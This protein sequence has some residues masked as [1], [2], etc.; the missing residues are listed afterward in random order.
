MDDNQKSSS[1]LLKEIS[2]LRQRVNELENAANNKPTIN[3]NERT[4]LQTLIKRL[5]LIY[6]KDKDCRKILANAAD[7]QNVG[8]HS[9]DEVLG[10]ND[11]EL[12]PED[13]ARSFF[14]DDQKV[15]KTG[16]PVINREEYF[17]TPERQEKVASYI[18]TSVKRQ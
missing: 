16:Q 1:E 9:E 11:F 7:I 10:K 5:D 18:K 13:I 4:L 8:K 3:Q 2:E 14:E 17:I 12:F 15:I 6:A